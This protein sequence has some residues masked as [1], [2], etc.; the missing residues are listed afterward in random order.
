MTTY[1]YYLLILRGLSRELGNTSVETSGRKIPKLEWT[2][3]SVI[4]TNSL[5]LRE[6]R[7]I[8]YVKR[9]GRRD[10]VGG[11]YPLKVFPMS[12]AS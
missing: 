9:E 5:R 8:S 11:A 3:V 4:L 12:E 7:R 6:W 1:S 2:S 10:E